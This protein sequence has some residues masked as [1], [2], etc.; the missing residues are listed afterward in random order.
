MSSPVALNWLVVLAAASYATATDLRSRRI[1]NHL[2]FPL[3]A[4][5]LLWPLLRG[6]GGL[7]VLDAVLGTLVAGLPFFLLW[8][9]GGTGEGDAKLMIAIG[10]WLGLD[11]AMVV[12]LSV[13]VAG[14]VLSIAWARRYGRLAALLGNTARL[15]VALPP[16]AQEK[17]LK[18]PYG[19]AIL[20]GTLAAAVVRQVTP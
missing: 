9:V 19:V 13:A 6:E 5:G 1:P 7:G 18:A 4:A 15:M 2:T 16:G 20:A 17:P 12:A 10:A 11:N 14:G 3:F 8:C